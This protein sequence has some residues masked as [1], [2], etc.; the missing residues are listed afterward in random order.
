VRRSSEEFLE[1][2]VLEFLHHDENVLISLYVKTVFS[3]ES[4][5]D[6][7]GYS[8]DYPKIMPSLVLVA[9]LGLCAIARALLKDGAI[10]EVV[11]SLGARPI[12]RAIGNVM[13]Q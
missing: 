11:D 6:Y 10:T 2:I 1:D 4:R 13:S 9:Y 5:M 3:S 7:P 8:Q 12:H